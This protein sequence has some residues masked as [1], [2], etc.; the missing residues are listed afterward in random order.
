MS[1]NLALEI[2]TY[3]YESDKQLYKAT[4]GAVAESRKV[5]PVFLERQPRQQRHATMLAA[6]T[7]PALDM[8]TANL[9]RTWLLKKYNGMLVDFLDS[10]GIA[11]K[12]GVVDDLPETVD[13]A[14]LRTAVDALVAK[15]PPEVVA[16]YLNA[17]SDMNEVNWPALKS[18]L[19][20]DQRLQLGGNS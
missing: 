11:H 3:A 16:V 4:L 15:Y 2:L 18:M 8:V 12:E 5:R 20:T 1:P 19:E 14:K 13:E 7:R 10:L 6:L 17:F 9:L